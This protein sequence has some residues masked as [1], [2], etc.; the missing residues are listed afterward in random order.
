MWG[1]VEEGRWMTANLLTAGRKRLKGST[2]RSPILPHLVF[3]VR[4]A[5]FVLILATYFEITVLSVVRF[6]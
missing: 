1:L 3:T 2:D 6:L 5:A 4:D